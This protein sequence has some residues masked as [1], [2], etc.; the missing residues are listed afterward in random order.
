MCTIF[1]ANA[2]CCPKSQ[3]ISE[4]T[5]NSPEAVEVIQFIDFKQTNAQ[6][7]LEH[8]STKQW[9]KQAENKLPGRP[10]GLRVI[11]QQLWCCCGYDGIVIFDSELQQQ[12]TI[13]ACMGYV[14]DAAEMSNGDVVIATASNGLYHRRNGECSG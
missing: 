1:K 7:T 8:A 2:P 3:I 14:C 5:R 11:N 4:N 6:M 10:Q 9:V 13:P 12:R